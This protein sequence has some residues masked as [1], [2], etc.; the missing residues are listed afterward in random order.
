MLSNSYLCRLVPGGRSIIR[1]D[2]HTTKLRFLCMKI[3]PP[4]VNTFCDKLFTWKVELRVA[5]M[6]FCWIYPVRYP[7]GLVALAGGEQVKY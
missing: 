7:V 2:P 6:I 5:P 3:P 1:L 4:P